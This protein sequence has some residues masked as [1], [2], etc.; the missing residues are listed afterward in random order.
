MDI[1]YRVTILEYGYE[2]ARHFKNID[3]LNSW[4]TSFNN[5]MP[6]E[7]PVVTTKK[8]IRLPNGDKIIS[9]LGNGE[10]KV[11]ITINTIILY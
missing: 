8:E 9:Y 7:H 11:R 2:K 6:H 4:L 1:I 10:E 5:L 3:K